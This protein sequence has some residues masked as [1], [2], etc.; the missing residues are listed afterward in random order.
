VRRGARAGPA[1][2]AANRPRPAGL[3][4]IIAFKLV[5]GGL[6]LA[7]ALGVYSLIGDDLA[8]ALE[9]VLRA[10]RI[11]PEREFFEALGTR[12]AHVT[13][14]TIGWIATGTL[15][16]AVLSLVEAVGLM[17]RWSWAGWVVI[18]ESAFFVPIEIHHL[19]RGF[20]PLLFAI[21]VV[22]VLIVIYLYRNRHRVLHRH[23]RR[24]PGG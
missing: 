15:L 9:S 18:G 17:F 8:A 14:S 5:K 6:L 12:L 13:P 4:A 24:A 20:A 3:Y 16:Y 19:M 11:D 10:L 22:N 7:L 23:G 21:L 2:V 1:E